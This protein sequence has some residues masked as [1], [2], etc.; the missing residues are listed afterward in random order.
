M[1]FPVAARVRKIIHVDMDAFY[2]SVEQRDHPDLCG[3]P[4]IVGGSPQSRG[5]VATASY[6]AR[7]YGVHSAMPS[8]QA[9]RLCPHA[10]FVIPRFEV[11]KAVSKQ[12]L[13]IFHQYTD[14]VEPL[15]LDEAYLDVTVNK[16]GEPSATRLALRVQE[17]ITAE[18]GLTASAGV[19]FNKFLA[20]LASGWKKPNG[21]TVIT[22][23]RASEFVERLPIHKF[24]GVGEVTERKMLSY[25][26]RT[27]VDLKNLGQEALR[28]R[29]GKMGDFFYRLAICQ[30]DREVNPFRIRK[31][32]GREH[33]YHTDIN[34][35]D[36]LSQALKEIC[37]DVEKS[38]RNHNLS[39][40]TVT[41]KVRYADF[42]T[43]SRSKSLSKPIATAQDIFNVASL[44][45]ERTEAR[46]KSVRLIGV[47]LSSLII[48]SCLESDTRGEIR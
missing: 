7:R 19:S 28:E 44:L 9:V 16:I 40:R 33:T 3:K 45:L 2:A 4:V 25:G 30:D 17:Q 27:G 18:T 36:Q 38:L 31:S 35:P 29:F 10:I 8:S 24:Y 43:I 41:L 32:V 47:S 23:D 6:E 26:I 34:D 22:P 5:V 11:Y 15:A 48:G 21:L 1:V 13:A 12:I 37:V 46:Y 39:G 42:K 20:K 14:I